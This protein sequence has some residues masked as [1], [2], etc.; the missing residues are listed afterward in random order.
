[1]ALIVLVPL[2]GSPATEYALSVLAAMAKKTDTRAVLTE[3]VDRTDFP[4]RPAAASAY[5]EGRA[6]VLRSNGVPVATNTLHGQ[7]AAAI[8]EEAQRQGAD[9][10]V[11]VRHDR[12]RLDGLLFRSVTARV[13]A[14]APCPLLILHA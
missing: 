9:L 6:S 5:L 2:D 7:A 14:A 11:M 4:A 12:E 3:V 10:I 13:L 8:V 1:M